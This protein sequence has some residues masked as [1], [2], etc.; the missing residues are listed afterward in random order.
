MSIKDP[1]D[2]WQSGTNYD[3]FMGRW[4]RLVAEEFLSWLPVPEN[5]AWLDVGCG[6]CVLSDLVLQLKRPKEIV[7]VD[8]SPEF[9]AFVTN[10]I[11]DPRLR[12]EVASAE[13][14][15]AEPDTFDAA[16]SGLAL[17]FMGQP[18]KVVAEMRR[19]T[20][21]GGIVAV[22]VWDYAEGMEMLRYF[23]DAAVA[24]D[25][26]AASLD[27][28]MRFPLCREAE[29]QK[30]FQNNELVD[31]QFR[32]IEVSTVFAGFEDYW[33]PFLGG[34]G[35]APGYVQGLNTAEREALKARLQS[36]L[37]K[38]DDGSIMLKARAWAIKSKV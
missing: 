23:W 26:S 37:P 13:N 17:N 34:V 6:T 10:A 24:L 3:R 18:E 27:E 9:I 21:S 11:S 32:G 8:A 25:E 35:P 7:A 16:V 31:I 2:S 4:S 22:Y 12:L 28:G 38:S 1:V 33:Q 19:V 15:P 14:I 20:K 30:L 36:T 29:I 5:G